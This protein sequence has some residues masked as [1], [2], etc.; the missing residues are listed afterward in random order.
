MQFPWYLRPATNCRASLLAILKCQA[1]PSKGPATNARES[2]AK[3]HG[4][5][6][7]L[8]QTPGHLLAGPCKC[9]ANSWQY[10][11]NVPESPSNP[12]NILAKLWQSPLKC[13]GNL[14]A[15][16]HANPHALPSTGHQ[17][18]RESPMRRPETCRMLTSRQFPM[19]I[20]YDK[21]WR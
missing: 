11:S 16:A 1:I 20:S 19:P 6:W 15:I 8:Q 13:Q 5:V 4:N 10:P 18:P 17:K 21:G 12:G 2:Q 14:Q 3:A 7:H 9:R